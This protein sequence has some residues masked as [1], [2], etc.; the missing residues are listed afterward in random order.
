VWDSAD[1]ELAWPKQLF[2]SELAAITSHPYRSWHRP[3]IE[4]LLR[5]AFVGEEPARAFKAAAHNYRDKEFV[6]GLVQH[7]SGLPENSA[8][9]PYWP[10]RRSPS[11]NPAPNDPARLYR[12][13]GG[14][15]ADL[16]RDGYLDK[17]LWQACPN[18]RS[19]PPTVDVA[20]VLTE[21]LGQD[22]AWPL[23]PEGWDEDTFLGVIEVF[24]DLVA[25]PRVREGCRSTR[26]PGH[27]TDFGV[28]TGRALYRWWVNRLLASGK[29]E[30]RLAEDGEDV[31]RLVRAVDSARGE[32]L[33]LVLATPEPGVRDRVAHA[34]ALFRGRAATEHDKR[35]A[36]VALANVLEDRR[37]LLK[38]SLFSDDEGALF[39]IANRFDLRHRNDKQHT[40]YDPAF[41]DWV[42]W[43]YLATIE[44]T[45][46]LLARQAG[47]GEETA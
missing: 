10:G 25:R 24:H 45:D 38:A 30:L 42:F 15:V 14:L 27:F 31:G 44:L 46:R 12:R 7:A 33:E 17:E 3:Q 29:S 2:L 4:S 9:R 35:S 20:A 6:A 1:Y 37:K 36:I 32:L 43:W 34:I 21:R 22:I 41:R 19:E 16:Y 8:L 40:D 23:S 47:R 13:F 39:Q 28:H 18:R 26:C 11:P 5:E